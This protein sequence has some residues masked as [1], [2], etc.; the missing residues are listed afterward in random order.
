MRQFG[1]NGQQR[2]LDIGAA[3]GIGLPFFEPLFQ[4]V[5]CLNYYENHSRELQQA[6][7]GRTAITADAPSIPLEDASV[8]FVVSLETLHCI[9][10]RR[11]DA[12]REVHR[13]LKPGGHFILRVPTEVGYVALIKYISRAI[14]GHALAEGMTPRMLLRHLF[15]TW[16][17]VTQYDKGRQ[18]GFDAYHF[19]RSVEPWFDVVASR[20]IP[21]PILFPFN[22]MVVG[23]K[24][25]RPS[26]D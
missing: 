20:V 22:L 15:P 5:V 8:S 6:Y 9:P 2:L 1:A 17:H 23:R 4:E 16:S 26:A 25:D 21:L 10:D 18:I 14:S 11:L 3:D 7:P 24:K 12:I 19:K 13:V